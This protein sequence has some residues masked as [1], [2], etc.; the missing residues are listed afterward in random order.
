MAEQ[1]SSTKKVA[2][3][4]ATV[5]TLSTLADGT[6]RGVLDFEP[7]ALGEVASHLGAP[8]TVIA[9]SPVN[10]LYS[11]VGI[12]RGIRKTLTDGT[13]RVL[14]DVDQSDRWRAW[15]LLGMPRETIVV[16]VLRDTSQ[17]FSGSSPYGDYAQALWRSRFL[18]RPR[19]WMA[20]G[21]LP[22]Y[23]EFIQKRPCAQ[24]GTSHVGETSVVTLQGNPY[25]SLPLCVTHKAYGPHPHRWPGGAAQ[26]KRLLEMHWGEWAHH[27]LVEALGQSRLRDTPPNLIWAWAEHHG[28][29]E[30]LPPVPAE[31]PVAEDT[32]SQNF[33]F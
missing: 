23:Q 15:P 4:T 8:G 27:A 24:P 31:S 9:L 29:A 32:A 11:I 1:D 33:I 12:S 2:A 7:A 13:V 5:G 16:A 6:L 30:F 17:R 25:W 18:L 10:G 28:L 22:R 20:L 19:V 26:A 14:Y 3:W 21:G